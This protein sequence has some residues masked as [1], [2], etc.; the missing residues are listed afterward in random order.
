MAR[1]VEG[2]LFDASDPSGEPLPARMRPRSMEEFVGQEEILGPDKILRRMIERDELRSAIFFG[3]PGSGKSTLAYLIAHRT[4]A[5][6]ETFSAVTS[7]IAEVR[8]AI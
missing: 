5:A 4:K 3:P 8:K 2:S 6:F 7:G 1:P